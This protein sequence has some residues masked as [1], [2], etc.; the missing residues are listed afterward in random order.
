MTQ[1]NW[2]SFMNDPLVKD[3][4]LACARSIVSKCCVMRACD[5]LKPGLA[6]RLLDKAL[7]YISTMTYLAY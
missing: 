2:T 7:F 6:L 4:A 1:K 5:R 3:L